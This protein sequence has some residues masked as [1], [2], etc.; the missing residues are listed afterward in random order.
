M[1]FEPSA[2]AAARH[3]MPKNLLALMDKALAALFA[4]N[5]E[6]G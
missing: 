1:H 6:H 4:S 2:V 3:H 5:V